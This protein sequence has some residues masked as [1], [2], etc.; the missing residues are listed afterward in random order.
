LPFLNT[1]SVFRAVPAVR[2]SFSYCIVPLQGMKEFGRAH[3][4]TIND[5]LLTILDMALNHYLNEKGRRKRK[6]LVADMPLALGSGGG[7]NQIAILQF[8]LG[9]A[10]AN[11]AERLRKISQQTRE[12]KHQV[13]GESAGAMIL[14]TAAIHAI[15]AVAELLGMHKMP[16]LAN[17]VISNVPL[18]LPGRNYLGGAE[19]EMILPLSVLAPG[20]S[21]NIT[22]ATYDKG[23]Q[24]AFLG[25]ASEFPDIK[26]LADYTVEA[27]EELRA[28]F[29]GLTTDKVALKKS[30]AGKLA[31]VKK[32]AVRERPNSAATKPARGTITHAETGRPPDARLAR[33]QRAAAKRPARERVARRAVAV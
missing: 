8:P 7:G 11:P 33:S 6:P 22:A 2:R 32:P 28:A 26:K 12:V 25:I 9:G 14:Y 4:A 20:Q 16:I 3:D 30:A 10:K 5:I 19:V 27:F 21:L 17:M 23:L 31:A 15:P 18:G 13:M 1:P 29:A 24:I